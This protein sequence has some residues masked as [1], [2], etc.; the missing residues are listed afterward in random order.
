MEN[1][2]GGTAGQSGTLGTRLLPGEV[3]VADSKE[4]EQKVR[5]LSR[6]GQT[7]RQIA[8]TY[9]LV[10]GTH[11]QLSKSRVQRILERASESPTQEEPE[12]EGHDEGIAEGTTEPTPSPDDNHKQALRRTVQKGKLGQTAAAFACF[13]A[14]KS[15]VD[16]IVEL[17]LTSEEGQKLFAEYLDCAD[18]DFDIDELERLRDLERSLESRAEKLAQKLGPDAAKKSGLLGADSARA[19][20]KALEELALLSG[21]RL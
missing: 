8:S 20:V 9:F 19:Y 14:G 7:V 2:T 13:R 21:V 15:L 17:D 18:I 1:G 6:Q 3:Q 11:Q 12:D 10:G 16:T 5:Q 4:L